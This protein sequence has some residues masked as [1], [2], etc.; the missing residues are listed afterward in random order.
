MATVGGGRAANIRSTG[1]EYGLPAPILWS[2][3]DHPPLI[4]TL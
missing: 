3:Q 4:Y 1:N 2:P